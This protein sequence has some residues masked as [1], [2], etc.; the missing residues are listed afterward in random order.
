[1]ADSSS[2]TEFISRN[3]DRITEKEAPMI[4]PADIVQLPKGQAFALLGG[5]KLWKLR[6]PLPYAGHD[7]M[8]PRSLGDMVEQIYPGRF[9][10]V[11][12]DG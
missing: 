4:E 1:M 9:A 5:G 7:P 11:S 12:Q 6:I 10:T 8:M 2:P 3:E